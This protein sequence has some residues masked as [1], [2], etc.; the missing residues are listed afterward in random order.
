VAAALRQAVVRAIVPDG[1]L[2]AH[3]W[4]WNY[5]WVAPNLFL[6]ALAALVCRRGLWR[7]CPAFVAFAI[8]SSLG[9]LAVFAADVIPPVSPETYWRI[10]WI[11]ILT[12]SML[13]F[14]VFGEVIARVFN[15]YSTIRKLGQ[16]SV[17]AVGGL[18]VLAAVLAA[19]LGNGD[20]PLRLI[21][22]AHLLEQ[23]VFL[24]ESGL[25][26]FL[27]AFAAYFRL[28]WN[29]VS[30]GVLLGMGISSCEHL[31][32]WAITANAGP[33]SHG[34]VLLA[35]LNM[36]TYHAAVLIWICYLLIPGKVVAKS[37]VPL[38]EHNLDV[39]NRE[40]ERL[41]QQ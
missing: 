38:P 33:S 30:F 14:L 39:W 5:L 13:K 6:L 22:G 8:F 2:Q 11:S 21:S 15:P 16:V 9:Q 35:F 24:I 37:A 18:L 27:F 32:N 23:T 19:A 12:E 1:M 40:L 10:D 28:P 41:L 26:V 4:L 3:S 25:I 17:S 20:S 31:A 29:R 34:R 7:Q 36:A